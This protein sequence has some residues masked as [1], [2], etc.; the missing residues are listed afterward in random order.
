M[1]H[2]K[3]D[4]LVEIASFYARVETL[5]PQAQHWVEA[6]VTLAQVQTWVEGTLEV[7]PR[8]ISELVTGMLRAGLKISP[9]GGRMITHRS[10]F[11][12]DLLVAH[13]SSN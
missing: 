9:V 4:A 11:P 5:T 2:H 1:A 7:A 3:Y 8:D 12:V 13:V 10:H 6:H